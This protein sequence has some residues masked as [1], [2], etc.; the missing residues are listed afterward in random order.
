L[1]KFHRKYEALKEK[2]PEFMAIASKYDNKPK[3]QFFEGLEGL[4]SIYE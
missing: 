2:L 4:K 1:D 3:V